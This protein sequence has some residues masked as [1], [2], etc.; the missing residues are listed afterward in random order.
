M[1]QKIAS[2]I[3]V[4]L[5]AMV[6][7]A[8]GQSSTNSDDKAYLVV[9]IPAQNNPAVDANKTNDN[10]KIAAISDVQA[11]ALPS[12]IS[13]VDITVIS[14]S[15]LIANG[16]LTVN[17]GGRL[18][19]AVTPH[20]SL[21]VSAKAYSGNTLSYEG[22]QLVSALRP[23]ER[24]DLNFT[25]TAVSLKPGITIEAA[26]AGVT[27]DNLKRCITDSIVNNDVQQVLTDL[28][29]TVTTL[30]CGEGYGI[31]SLEGLQNFT[32]ITELYLENNFITNLSPLAVAT[33]D[34]SKLRVLDLSSSGGCECDGV[35]DLEPLKNITSLEVFRN[36]SALITDISPLANLT[37]LHEL[38]LGSNNITDISPLA[39][40]TQLHELDLLYNNIVDISTINAINMPLLETLDLSSNRINDL[41]SLAGLSNLTY[42]SLSE[43]RIDNISSLATL[44]SLTDIDLLFNNVSDVSPLIEL[45]GLQSVNLSAN[46]V[47]S[48]VASLT[49]LTNLTRIYFSSNP[50]MPCSDI[51]SLDSVLDAGLVTSSPA[52]DGVVRWSSCFTDATADSIQ[53]TDA[54]LRDCVIPDPNNPPLISE[55]TTLSCPGTPQNKITDLSGLEQLVQLVD[56]DL[57]GNNIQSLSPITYLRK[58]QNLNISENIPLS[59]AQSG[60]L[61]VYHL[62]LLQNLRSLNLA[63]DTIYGFDDAVNLYNLTSL[64][65]NGAQIDQVDSIQALAAL[66]NADA[67][68]FA[69]ATSTVAG[70]DI[71]PSLLALDAVLDADDVTNDP[72]STGVVTW[73]CSPPM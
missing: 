32:G 36:S 31:Q 22:Q 40:L 62:R 58:L 18:T 59:G 41:T 51:N 54:M 37:Q 43:N 8:C 33:G 70:T 61:N 23:G 20:L 53:F 12:G 21:T 48:G 7:V 9:S 10:K 63:K 55:V 67:I 3:L 2:T 44:Q 16:S 66:S 50:A 42:I 24:A 60:S 6:L 27:D 39:N 5:L 17:E 45:T 46:A 38:D 68:N 4:T 35:A 13:R 47:E 49:G 30:F 57:H 72:S 14:G 1:I 64:D 29:S 15:E 19:L 65:V 25:L 26:L 52:F 11:A 73:L 34:E 69:C 71:T 28:A 56:L